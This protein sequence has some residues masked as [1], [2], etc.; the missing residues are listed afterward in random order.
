[1]TTSK[2]AREV[3]QPF[4]YLL[5]DAASVASRPEEITHGDLPQ[6]ATSLDRYEYYAHS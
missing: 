6:L 4:G 1:M 2:S 3:F 5:D